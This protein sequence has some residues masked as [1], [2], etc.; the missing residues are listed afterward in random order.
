MKLKIWGESGK[1]FT[2]QAKLT[3]LFDLNINDMFGSDYD[4]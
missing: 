3:K 1:N 2:K 4:N